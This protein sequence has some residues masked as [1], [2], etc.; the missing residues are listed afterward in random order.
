[1]IA[2][3]RPSQATFLKEVD[4]AMGIEPTT[5]GSGV[6][7]SSAQLAAQGHQE[8][9]APVRYGVA[10]DQ[11]SPDHLPEKH[12]IIGRRPVPVGI[13]DC[14]SGSQPARK[15]REIAICS[16]RGRTSSGRSGADR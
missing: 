14:Q 10:L 16:G 6:R 2:A 7:S 15:E 11:A 1:M 8:A 13:P 4:R 12:V 5:P 3:S 9:P